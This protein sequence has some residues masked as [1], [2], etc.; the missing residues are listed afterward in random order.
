ML[1]PFC[2]TGTTGLAALALGRRF[3]GIDLNP[4]FA[5]LAAE[6]LRHAAEHRPTARKRG[7]AAHDRHRQQPPGTATAQRQR[8][9]LSP[10]RPTNPLLTPSQNAPGAYPRRPGAGPG[11]HHAGRTVTAP[12][13]D[14][15]AWSLPD[16]P[17]ALTP[18]AARA[19]L[20]ILLKAQRR[21]DHRGA[22]AT[23]ERQP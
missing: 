3:T 6:R 15:S 21:K 4:A 20:R 19:L 8:S 22:S 1:D 5:A 23:G 7:T 17:P 10:A 16:E 9:R 14:P 12:A 2:G 18:A 13:E 11:R